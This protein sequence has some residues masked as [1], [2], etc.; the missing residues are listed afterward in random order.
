MVF[1]PEN[2]KR[3]L[4]SRTPTSTHQAGAQNRPPTKP[5][6]RPYTGY[7]GPVDTKPIRP[8]HGPIGGASG[9][10]TRPKPLPAIPSWGTQ[11]GQ[12]FTD[13]F[14]TVNPANRYMAMLYDK[15]KANDAS[16]RQYLLNSYDQ[17]LWRKNNE[18]F[19]TWLQ[20][21]PLQSLNKFAQQRAAY[22]AYMK[23]QNPAGNVQYQG[24]WLQA[25]N[26]Q[27]TPWQQM[28]GGGWL[29]TNSGQ[30][31]NPPAAAQPANNSFE[32]QLYQQL[33]SSIMGL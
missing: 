10:P 13:W 23:A 20:A 18:G 2:T 21:N 30:T 1:Y 24:P 5:L 14:R 29:N 6:S 7:Q 27:N 9:V 3:P 19:G 11:L 22:E 17:H 31:W 26:A 4:P 16:A 28:V 25:F 12:G 33:L 15:D 32:T 8:P